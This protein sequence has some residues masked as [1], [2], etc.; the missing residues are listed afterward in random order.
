MAGAAEGWTL[1][2]ATLVFGLAAVLQLALAA[3]PDTM[4]DLLF[5]RLWARNLAHGGLAEAYWPTSSGFNPP[6]DYPPVFPYLLRGLAAVLPASV[7]ANDRLLD[8]AIRV[9]LVAA[10]LGLGA[11]IAREGWKAA[12]LFLFNPAVLFHTCYWGQ[13]DALWTLLVL[14]SLSMLARSRAGWSCA[15]VAAAA[16][17][18]PLAY[19]YAALV[20]AAVVLRNPP[21]Q[22]ARAAAAAAVTVAVLLAPFAALHR[23]GPLLRALAFQIDAMPYATVNAHNLWWLLGAG[24]PWRDARSAWIGPLAP[25]TV[26]TVLFVAFFALSLLRLR[27]SQDARALRLACAGLALAF[28]VL[29]T[30]MHENH[31]FPF[32][33]LVASL[34]LEDRRLRLAYALVSATFLANMALHDPY[35]GSVLAAHA[36]GPAVTLHQPVAQDPAAV[37]YL[38]ASGYRHLLDELTRPAPVGW[39]VLTFA[40]SLVNVAVLVWWIATFL[41]PRSFDAALAAGRPA[42]RRTPVAAVA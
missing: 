27:R 21:R 17:A 16:L 18:K 25:E 20:A 3:L 31:L 5:Y 37:R 29:C 26:G 14:A 4:G 2:P 12:A 28:F 11:L 39:I 42:P 9:P 36:P 7:L 35:L 15:L 22:I 40:N 19:P 6:V 41:V 38:A 8:F 34:G 24:L 33:P 10:N 30:H 1:K 23:L 13:T 32:L